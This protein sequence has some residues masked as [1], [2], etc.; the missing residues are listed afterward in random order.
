[1]LFQAAVHAE[2]KKAVDFFSTA[3]TIKVLSGLAFFSQCG[4]SKEYRPKEG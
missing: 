2:L 3:L 1:M 4:Y